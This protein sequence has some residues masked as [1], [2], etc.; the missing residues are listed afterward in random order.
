MVLYFTLGEPSILALFLRVV[1]YNQ[2]I[3]TMNKSTSVRHV[4]F[5]KCDLCGN[6]VAKLVDQG[7][8]LVCC[9]ETMHELL[10]NAV[11]EENRK[12]LP[13][14]ELKD[15]VLH[16]KSCSNTHCQPEEHDRMFYWIATACGGYYLDPCGKHEFTVECGAERPTALYKYCSRHGLWC[17]EL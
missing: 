6:V 1:G 12:Y 4:K 5:F 14:V 7:T 13:V 9:G 3:T 16:I 15:G 10:P 11:T 8:P 17:V 2:N